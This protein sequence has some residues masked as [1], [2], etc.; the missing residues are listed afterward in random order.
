MVIGADFHDLD[1]DI[2][3]LRVFVDTILRIQP[4]IVCLAGDL[5]D[6]YEFS[7]Y[8]QDPREFD[9]VARIQTGHSI[10]WE[11]RDAAPNA[12]ID[13]IEGNHEMRLLRHLADATPAMLTVLSDLHGMTVSSLLGLD[14]FEVNYH[15]RGSLK[16]RSFSERDHKRELGRNWKTYFDCVLAHH[17]PQ[18]QKMGMPG[19]HG[20]HHLHQV[21]PHHSVQYGGPYEW[22]QLGGMCKRIATY[23]DGERWSNGFLVVHVDT[24]RHCP[25]FE[26]IPITDFAVVGGE[27]YERTEEEKTWVDPNPG[28][29]VPEWD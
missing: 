18:G 22:H 24:Q 20:H 7:R 19:F 14:D 6:L 26:Y 28:H 2:F 13:L 8:T 12:Q 16:A 21:W 4:E 5:F 29:R 3:A 25:N 1:V 27:Y 17:F 9:P 10:L 15:G 23:T 11:I